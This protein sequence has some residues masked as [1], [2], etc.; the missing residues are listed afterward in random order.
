MLAIL[1]TILQN[2]RSMSWITRKHPAFALTL[3]LTL[4]S[5]VG[6]HWSFANFQR[7]LVQYLA[8]SILDEPPFET[9]ASRIAFPK[10]YL[11]VTQD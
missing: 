9:W 10:A 1:E 8:T 11:A 2:L 6:G 4:S 3:I 7:E 5:G